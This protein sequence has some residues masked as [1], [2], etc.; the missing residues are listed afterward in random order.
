[1]TNTELC[2]TPATELARLIRT[3]E[4][5]PVELMRAVLERIERLN[6]E[7]NCFCTVTAEAAMAAAREAEQAVMKGVAVFPS[8]LA[9]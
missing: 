2:Y 5:T 1:M 4:L 8:A 3:K 6:R 7:L 9:L